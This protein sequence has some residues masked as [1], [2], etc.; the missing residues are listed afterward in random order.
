MV[1]QVFLSIFLCSQ[2]EM[3]YALILMPL[4]PYVFQPPTIRNG[5]QHSI[6]T[7]RGQ[8]LIK[9]FSCLYQYLCV[10]AI[11]CVVRDS[12][13]ANSTVY[14]FQLATFDGPMILFVCF[15]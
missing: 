3:K 2:P 1:K 4:T 15:F 8:W 12:L 13:T 6:K 14:H 7:K 11:T 10:T 9:I 5:K